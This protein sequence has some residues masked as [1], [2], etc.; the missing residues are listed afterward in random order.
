MQKL[1]MV[2]EGM[3]R[4]G[5]RR[6]PQAQQLWFVECAPAAPH[7][8][9]ACHMYRTDGRE[10]RK[11]AA[12][13]LNYLHVI[14]TFYTTVCHYN[15]SLCRARPSPLCAE[16]LLGTRNTERLCALICDMCETESS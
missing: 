11:P 15:K 4:M 7:T 5:P 14:T 3:R 10:S 16:A 1:S 8:R 2:G 9:L 6:W 12:Y 13:L